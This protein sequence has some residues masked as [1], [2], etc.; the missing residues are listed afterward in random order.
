M[1]RLA[2]GRGA[3]G[4]PAVHCGGV[5]GRGGVYLA[6]IV[7][8][9]V[10]LSRERRRRTAWS[11]WVQ[12]VNPSAVS[13]RLSIYPSVRRLSWLAAAPGGPP[14][15]LTEPQAAGPG[16]AGAGGGLMPSAM[17]TAASRNELRW[18][19]PALPL[20][21]SSRK[22]ECGWLWNVVQVPGKNKSLHFLWQFVEL[23][24]KMCKYLIQNCLIYENKNG[25]C[26][27]LLL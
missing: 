27:M 14:T 1:N 8:G 18:P 9:V 10:L 16:R 19:S 17:P 25:V 12:Y 2:G 22:A 5:A 7:P 20:S 23:F 6:A 3:A 24:K 11:G 4:R 26:K 13:I 15:Y 21:F